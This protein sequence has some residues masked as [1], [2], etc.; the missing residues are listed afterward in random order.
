[1]QL[2]GHPKLQGERPGFQVGMW[3]Q[4]PWLQR[5][6]V[7]QSTRQRQ[8][9][10]EGTRGRA[11]HPG[12]LGRGV[13]Y[14]SPPHDCMCDGK[15]G[16]GMGALVSWW[17]VVCHR[18]MPRCTTLT[19]RR[20]LKLSVWQLPLP[21]QRRMWR[22]LQRPAPPTSHD[23]MVSG[24]KALLALSSDGELTCVVQVR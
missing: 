16:L 23:L 9:T 3:R 2:L 12:H 18:L 24:A 1:M 8:A 10:E 7:G 22:A 15:V 6:K 11:M 5:Q 13:S 20:R 4:W 19:H 14:H 21:S 17:R